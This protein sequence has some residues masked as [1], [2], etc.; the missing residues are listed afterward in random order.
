[1]TESKKARV[2]TAFKMDEAQLLKAKY[3]AWHE[4]VT[5][6]GMIVNDL[7][8]RIT[9]FEKDNGGITPAMVKKMEDSK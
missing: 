4:R 9:K 5:L 7:E 1:M 2:M 8:K 6:T 3:V